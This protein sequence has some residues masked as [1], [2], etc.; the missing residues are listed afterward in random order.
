MASLS[1]NTKLV[2]VLISISGSA[3]AALTLISIDIM[4]QSLKKDASLRLNVIAT[5]RIQ[6]LKNVWNLRLQ[7]VETLAQ[8]ADVK[9]LLITASQHSDPSSLNAKIKEGLMKD[10]TRLTL[11]RDEQIYDLLIADAN[12]QII[13]SQDSSKEGQS[14][15]QSSAF[16]EGKSRAHY[17]IEF[18][19]ENKKAML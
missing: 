14:I 10:F 13:L 17:N 19:S 6:T 3:I 15:S 1:L 16:V 9:S 5:D 11:D 4:Q 18:D 7:Q 2:I 12:G 8:D